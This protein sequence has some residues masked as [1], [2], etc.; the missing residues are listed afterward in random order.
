M[1]TTTAVRYPAASVVAIGVVAALFL[2]LFSAIP[3]HTRF[4]VGIKVKP[5]EF[6]PRI[7]ETIRQPVD[8]VKLPP[9]K[10]TPTPP[11]PHS[12]PRTDAPPID[13]PLEPPTPIA[14][15][16]T[17]FRGRVDNNETPLVRPDPVYPRKAIADGTEGWVELQFTI[18]GAGTVANVAVVDSDPKGVFDAAASKAVQSWKHAPRVEDGRAI[19]RRGVRVVLRFDMT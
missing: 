5:I 12:G 16:P 19:E 8:H 1:V 4:D 7:K 17:G 9:L 15:L 13:I 6:T 10:L 3:Q 18:T 11:I 14:G 2:S